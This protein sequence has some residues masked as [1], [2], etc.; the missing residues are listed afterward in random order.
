MRWCEDNGAD[1]ILGLAKNPRLIE[2]IKEEL[3]EAYIRNCIAGR[4]SRIFHEFEY[5]PLKTQ[6]LSRRV[7]AEAEHLYKG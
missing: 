5:S 1:Y 2:K 6:S 7:I 4:A 3:V